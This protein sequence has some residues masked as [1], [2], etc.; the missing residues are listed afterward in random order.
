MNNDSLKNSKRQVIV[1]S[2]AATKSLIGCIILFLLVVSSTAK[3]KQKEFN[4]LKNGVSF[5]LPGTWKTISDE[6]LPGKG[7]YYSAE[8][9]GKN[10]SGLF[11]LV[12]INNMEKPVKALLVQMQNMKESDLY[13]DS[14]IE[15]TAIEVGR[16]GSMEGNRM[17]YESVVKGTKV[18]GT[19][20]C[21]NCSEKTYIVFLQTGISDQKNNIKAFDLIE[22]TFACR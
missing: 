20:Y 19:I 6:S 10:A 11:T 17:M 14:G 8:S 5:S 3:E 21:F 9:T 18:T 2:I 4:Y 12:T 13:K 16:F 22:L 7:Y 1:Y 15:F